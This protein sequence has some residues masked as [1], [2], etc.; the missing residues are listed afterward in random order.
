MRPYA[1]YVVATYTPRWQVSAD[2]PTL[3]CA[4]VGT[5]QSVPMGMLYAVPIDRR[6][7]H[8][9]RIWCEL[10]AAGVREA[11]AK[12]HEVIAL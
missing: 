10:G 8:L 4:K 2:S 6:R 9:L 5:D 12:E 11:L 3:A 1:V 7:K